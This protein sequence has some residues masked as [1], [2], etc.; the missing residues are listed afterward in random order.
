MKKIIT[1]L[2]LA[3][4]LTGCSGLLTPSDQELEQIAYNSI[5]AECT[6]EL[7]ECRVDRD[8]YIASYEA[9]EE[10]IKL[11]IGQ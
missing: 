10:D 1:I 3:V 2:F 7:K 8:A 5:I 6:K 9:C 4:I 11:W